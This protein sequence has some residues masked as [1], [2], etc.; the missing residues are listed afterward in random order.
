MQRLQS[1]LKHS[2]LCGKHRD[3]YGEASC[4]RPSRILG[5]TRGQ[6]SYGISNMSNLRNRR[7]FFPT[8]R[9]FVL[10]TSTVEVLA[11]EQFH[12]QQN[13]YKN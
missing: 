12:P 3:G 7:T 8:I 13:Q 2:L 4:R 1:T 10:P 5:P 11:K 9:P 6:E